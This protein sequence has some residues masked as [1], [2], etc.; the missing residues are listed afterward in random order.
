M[1]FLASGPGASPE[2]S[3]DEE[4]TRRVATPTRR[5]RVPACPAR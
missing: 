4:L 3:D 1:R 2:A 5:A